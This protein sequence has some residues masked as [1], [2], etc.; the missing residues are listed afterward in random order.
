MCIRDRDRDSQNG[1]DSQ[2]QGLASTENVKPTASD[3]VK[4]ESV[5][6]ATNELASQK[7][8]DIKPESPV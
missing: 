4:E 1:E 8:E 6:S 3:E 5:Q 7:D 2:N